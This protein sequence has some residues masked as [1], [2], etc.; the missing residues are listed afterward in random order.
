MDSLSPLNKKM[1][2][3][4]H[5]CCL[6]P[7]VPLHAIYQKGNKFLPIPQITERSEGLLVKMNILLYTGRKLKL[8]L[9][10]ETSG[11]FS[12]TIATEM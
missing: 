6:R 4:G 2:L 12:D 7:L 5:H 1:S 3:E 10:L 9:K 8:F 11:L